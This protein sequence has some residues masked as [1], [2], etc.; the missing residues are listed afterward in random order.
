MQNDRIDSHKL[1]YHPLEVA[2]WLEGETVYPINAEICIYGG[3]QS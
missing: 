3:V 1:I 2:R